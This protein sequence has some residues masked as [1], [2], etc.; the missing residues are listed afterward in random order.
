[1]MASKAFDFTTKELSL[2]TLPD[3]EKLLDSHPAPG[4]AGCWCLYHHRPT[5]LPQS[6]Y[7]IPRAERAARNRAAKRKLVEDGCAHGM[8][9]YAD[10]EPVGWCQ[11][12]LKDEL[13]RMDNLSPYR[14]LAADRDAPKLWRITCFVVDR[15]FRG[16]GVAKIA[17][18]AA[19]EAIR[20]KGGGVVEAYPIA[21]W[22]AYTS[23]RGTVT[24]FKQAG[25]EVV[26]PLTPEL[27][28]M[29]KRIRARAA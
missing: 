7:K 29:R 22:R 12:G 9:V 24:M 15:K 8:L 13:P 6:E 21:H 18:K 17:L 5:G 28:L 25:F 14:K 3:F 4:A 2:K 19:L 20:K 26:A 10:G 23:Y 16:Q 1:M 11:F 27:V